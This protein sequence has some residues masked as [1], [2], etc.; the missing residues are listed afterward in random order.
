MAPREQLE[1]EIERLAGR[2]DR[3]TDAR[4]IDELATVRRGLASTAP[5][6]PGIQL[7]NLRI[8]FACKQRWEDMIGDERVRACGGCDRPVFNLSAMRRADA[9]AVLATRGLTPC[10]RFYRRPDGTVMTTDCPTGA[11]PAPRRLAVVATSL[12][13]ASTALGVSPAAM[14][15]PPPATAGTTGT[16]LGTVT[17]GKTG[18]KLA[19]VTIVV[20]SP[21]LWQA[22]TA[23]TD[24]DGTY[25]V[26]QLPPGDY[27][28]TYYYADISVERAGIHVGID[29]TTPVFEQLSTAPTGG[30]P[31]YIE[32]GGISIADSTITMGVPVE[33]GIV[34]PA[35]RP[36]IE[37]SVWGRVGVGVA[38]QQPDAVARR[39]TAPDAGLAS[40]WEAALAA[41]VTFGV[42]RDGDLRLGA[43]GELRTSSGPV[44]GA[45]LVLEGLPPAPYDSRIGG[46][47]S[48]VLRAGS[49][50][51]VITAA[52]GFGYVGSF[53][54][55]DPWVR[56][57][58]HVVG[59]RVLVSVDR[60]VDQPHDWSATLGLEVEPIGAV[61]ALLDLVTGR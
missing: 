11:R 56:W 45:E 1:Q 42:A 59:A 14:A 36:A 53:P 24:E 23:I 8:G 30:E 35:K 5:R 3:A 7:P 9:E 17:D 13:A 26:Q 52:L 44:A 34:M 28:V 19:G 21:A 2:L 58:R 33:P 39:V 18:E 22:Q 60:A 43:W 10:V 4:S 49:N 20:T 46:T 55:S 54:R 32:M 47:G 31:I 27:V 25:Q 16:I 6:E 61:H 41:D 50:A 37:W 38:S 12:A 29:E 15:D 48:L 40:T 57:A 51:H